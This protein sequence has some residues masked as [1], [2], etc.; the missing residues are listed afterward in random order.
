M[1]NTKCSKKKNYSLTAEAPFPTHQ[2][3]ELCLASLQNPRELLKPHMPTCPH[4]CR[5]SN[6]IISAQ[7]QQWHERECWW[8]RALGSYIILGWRD[9][10]VCDGLWKR[11]EKK[12]IGLSSWESQPQAGPLW[13]AWYS[14]KPVVPKHAAFHQLLLR[15]EEEEGEWGGCHWKEIGQVW[16]L[17]W[18]KHCL[19]P[20]LREIKLC[21]ENLLPSVHLASSSS[22]CQKGCLTERGPANT[23][24]HHA[25]L[26]AMASVSGLGVSTHPSKKPLKISSSKGNFD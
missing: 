21:S 23:P 13:L 6:I 10:G 2:A 17:A 19:S 18:V 12:K 25:E 20:M 8:E 3:T 9:S 1:Q 4:Y 14:A 7:Y 11:Q 5:V 26:P 22:L 15:A 24:W 16:R